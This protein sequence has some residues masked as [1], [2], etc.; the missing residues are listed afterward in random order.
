ML[1]F[2]R[3]HWLGRLVT[4]VNQGAASFPS[5]PL[6]CRSVHAARCWAGTG[7]WVRWK[8]VWVFGGRVDLFFVCLFVGRLIFSPGDSWSKSLC[9]LVNFC[10]RTKAGMGV[11]RWGWK[12]EEGGNILVPDLIYISFKWPWNHIRLYTGKKKKKSAGHEHHWDVKTS[13]QKYKWS[14][15]SLPWRHCYQRICSRTCY[16]EG[17]GTPM[18]HI[19]FFV[20]CSSL[21]LPL[22]MHYTAPP[23]HKVKPSLQADPRLHCLAVKA[24]KVHVGSFGAKLLTMD[25]AM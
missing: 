24:L 11:H 23:L 1:C 16:T 17:A 15:P 7:K 3:V 12:A 13:G 19:T 25:F 8:S 2:F 18:L 5:L 4:V 9:G 10:G 14:I 20:S 21:M 22:Y 6:C